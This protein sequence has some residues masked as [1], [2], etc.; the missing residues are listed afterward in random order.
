MQ[1]SW[2]GAVVALGILSVTSAS[3][4]TINVDFGS[5]A[6]ITSSWPSTSNAGTNA[7]VA[8][9]GPLQIDGGILHR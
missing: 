3:A 5:G 6:G 2:L 4:V 9:S 1:G 7:A 8:L